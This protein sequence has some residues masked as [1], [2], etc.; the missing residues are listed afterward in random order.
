MRRVSCVQARTWPSSA[1][2]AG[3]ASRP[4]RLC[5][6]TWR[7]TPASAA[8]SAA[9]A[10]GPSPATLHSSAT[11]AR[12]QVSEPLPSAVAVPLQGLPSRPDHHHC[13]YCCIT[14]SACAARLHQQVVP[15]IR[16]LR[17]KR[18][19]IALTP[20]AAC[21]RR[22]THRPFKPDALR[23]SIWCIVGKWTVL[24][25]A[26]A[27]TISANTQSPPSLKRYTVG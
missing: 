4:R 1:C 10:T 25:Y 7:C 8:T 5:S 2:C 18:S 23:D 21:F 16:P 17:A 12:T 27:H 20:R 6:S 11:Y 9:S 24:C 13:V 15:I 26:P 3:S 14:V 22:K 19:V